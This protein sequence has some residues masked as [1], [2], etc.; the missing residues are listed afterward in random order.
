MC[1][2]RIDVRFVPIADIAP[3]F[4]AGAGRSRR[5][6]CLVLPK[7]PAKRPTHASIL[8]LDQAG[9]GHAQLDAISIRE[10]TPNTAK[11]VLLVP[12]GTA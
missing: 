12:S 6:I 9:I 2:A 4:C 3:T 10:G 8:P 7:T 5:A 1:G 11:S